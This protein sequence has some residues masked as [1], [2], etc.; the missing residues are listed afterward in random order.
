MNIAPWALVVHGG[1]G[2]GRQLEDGCRDAAQ[3]GYA[4]LHGHGSALDT[5]VRAVARM[6]DDGRFNA[7]SGSVLGLDGATIEMDAAVMDSC[8]RLGAVAALRLVRNPVH[9][10]RAVC[11]TPHHLLCGE[12]A[13]RFARAQGHGPYTHISE[14]VRASHRDMQQQLQSAQPELP[15]VDN[16]AFARYWNYP[17]ACDTVGAVARDGDG[18]FAVAASTG[19]TA[20]ALLGR[21]GDTP[22]I[23]CGFYAGPLGAVAATGVGEH[24][25]RH[26]LAHTVY[27]WLAEGM[28]LAAALRR[29]IELFPPEVD[30]GL[31][32]VTREEAGSDSNRPM[33]AWQLNAAA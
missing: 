16:A 12:G 21:V 17:K 6:E 3:A 19:G 13:L 2:A 5:A 23:G 15:G 10:A 26:L 14:R 33:P 25:M 30:V 11:E 27:R 22:L 29:G 9:V 32:A 4:I 8:G 7:G 1:S 28:P 31:I 24:I 20:P 18:H